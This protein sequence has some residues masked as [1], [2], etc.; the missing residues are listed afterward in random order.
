MGSARAG[1]PTSFFGV[2]VF[3]RSADP[4]DVTRHQMDDAKSA[5]QQNLAVRF[6]EYSVHGRTY[7]ASIYSYKC[8]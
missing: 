5:E 3:S 2:P 7:P 4:I 8:P 6:L 1:R